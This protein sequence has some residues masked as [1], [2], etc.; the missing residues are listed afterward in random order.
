M[1]CRRTANAALD[2]PDGA[3]G[4]APGATSRRSPSPKSNASVLGFAILA[5]T[6]VVILFVVGCMADAHQSGCFVTAGLT[7]RVGLIGDVFSRFTGR[8]GVSDGNLLT[9]CTS[10]TPITVSLVS[11]VVGGTLEQPGRG[12]ARDFPTRSHGRYASPDAITQWV[13]TILGFLVTG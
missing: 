8:R 5:G 4:A 3:S 9:S 7:G 12:A 2:A 1:G 10:I 13:A 11:V 6:R